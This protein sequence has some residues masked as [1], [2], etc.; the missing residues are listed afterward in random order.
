MTSRGEPT[1]EADFEKL[2][3]D[4]QKVFYGSPTKPGGDRVLAL[5]ARYTL[6]LAILAKFLERYGCKD[7]ADRFTELGAALIEQRWTTADGIRRAK[8]GGDPPDGLALWS[9]RAMVV[10]GLECILKSGKMTLKNAAKYIANNY[11]VFD[12]LKRHPDRSLSTSIISWRRAIREGKNIPAIEEIL[13]HQHR[14]LQG[15]PAVMFARGEQLLA[16]AA[17]DTTKAAF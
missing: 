17:E 5:Q 16:E 15:D 12:R 8:A 6:A 1:L 2:K 10:E 9:R 11:P 4:L 14:V 7:V 13:A 3:Q